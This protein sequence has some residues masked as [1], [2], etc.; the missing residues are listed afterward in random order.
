MSTE[1]PTVYGAEPT[2]NR[3]LN[4]GTRV[5]EGTV[6]VYGDNDG[7]LHACPECSTYRHLKQGAGWNPDYEPV[8]NGQ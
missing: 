2:G 1:T 4:C 3:C 7:N 8:V 6:G 5:L